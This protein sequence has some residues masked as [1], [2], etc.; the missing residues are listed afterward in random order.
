MATVSRRRP[1]WRRSA[2]ATEFVVV[3]RGEV[4]VDQGNSVWMSSRS[5]GGR[6]HGTPARGRE[7]AP[8]A[9]ARAPAGSA[10][11]RRAA[12]SASPPR[13]RRY[14]GWP[15]SATCRGRPRPRCAEGRRGGARR[16]APG[17]RPSRGVFRAGVRRRSPPRS[18]ARLAHQVSPPPRERAPGLL[19]PPRRSAVAVGDLAQTLGYLAL[20]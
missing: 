10:C 3:Q 2:P 17:A 7:S 5:T 12:S 4:V 9:R 11:R 16:P 15:R 13:S 18:R 19:P 20:L 8:S 1:T 14:R 6:Q